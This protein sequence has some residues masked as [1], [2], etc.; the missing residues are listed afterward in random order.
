M[1]KLTDILNALDNKIDR[2]NHLKKGRVVETKRGK[3]GITYDGDITRMGRVLVYIT[4]GQKVVASP[5]SLKL[6]GFV[7]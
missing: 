3:I 1:S 4:D 7:D 6:I 2:P 5:S